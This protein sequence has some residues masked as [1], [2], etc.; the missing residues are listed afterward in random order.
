M[1]ES[2]CCVL[3]SNLGN[4]L[5]VDGV[6]VQS[7]ELKMDESPLTGESDLVHNAVDKDPMLL[8]GTRVM[9]GPRRMLV[10]AVDINSQ[11]GII[12][13]LLGATEVDKAAKKK[14]KAPG[15]FLI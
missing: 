1:I 10:T 9:E 7:N 12:M 5:P 15:T 3:I 8:S 6:V 14:K 11:T 2:L 13:G 4:T